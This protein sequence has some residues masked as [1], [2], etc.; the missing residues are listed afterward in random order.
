MAWSRGFFRLWIVLT[1]IWIGAIWISTGTEEFKGLWAPNVKLDVEY[2]GGVRDTL[3][4]SRPQEYLRQQIL[5]GVTEGAK[6]LAQKGDPLEAKAQKEAANSTADELLKV[7][8]DEKAKRAD[9][10]HRALIPLIAPPA[11]LLVIGIA[12]AWIAGGF[13][14][15]CV[16]RKPFRVDDMTE[17]PKLGE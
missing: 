6:L 12:I 9:R 7:T 3:D 2:K 8:A 10:L 13:R 11:S 15:S 4:G 5:T 14:R 16:Y 1:L 17:S